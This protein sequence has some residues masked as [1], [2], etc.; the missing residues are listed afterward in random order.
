[1]KN[2]SKHFFWIIITLFIV[3]I[4]ILDRMLVKQKVNKYKENISNIDFQL[5]SD[6]YI[7]D[8]VYSIRKKYEENILKLESNI[9]SGQDL[10][11]Q[12]E[13]I[14]D[15]AEEFQISL[16]D[17]EIDPRNTLPSEINKISKN[18]IQLERQTLSVKLIGPF[19][20]IGNF[21]E[22]IEHRHTFLHL[23][24]CSFSLDSLNPTGVIADVQYVTYGQSES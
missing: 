2:K 5:Q 24:Q 19:L 10:I 20:S 15:L 22:L 4:Y 17:L 9:L 18:K 8:E 6:E 12:I 3:A 1:M 16:K 7:M 21:L 23:K 14:K 11:H 13:K